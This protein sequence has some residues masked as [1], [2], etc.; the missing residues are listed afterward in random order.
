MD[1]IAKVLIV[2]VLIFSSQASTIGIWPSKS[3]ILITPIKNY[4]EAIYLVNPSNEDLYVDVSFACKNND[5]T[6]F[7]DVYYP[8]KYFIPKNSSFDDPQTMIIVFREKTFVQDEINLFNKTIKYYKIASG[9]R[10][11]SCMLELK[12]K[13]TTPVVLTSAFEIEL[14]GFDVKK[15]V[16]ILFVLIFLAY[17]KIKSVF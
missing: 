7:F 16:F 10:K 2:L 8:S 15:L 12:T 4:K 9:T 17:L 14:K 1:T 3:E 13:E 6:R 11:F 5:Y